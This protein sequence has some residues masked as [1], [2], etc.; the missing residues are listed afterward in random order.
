MVAK[1]RREIKYGNDSL[2]EIIAPSSNRTIKVTYWD[3]WIAIILSDMFDNNLGKMIDYLR[4]KANKT[5]HLRNNFEAIVNHIRLLNQ[6]YLEEKL[7]ITDI[8][9]ELDADFKKKQR[10]KAKRKILEMGFQSQEKSNWMINTPRKLHEV[11]AMRGH[12][13]LFP[14]SPKNHAI[15][16]EN[17]YK[18]PGFYNEEQSFKLEKKLDKYL[19]KNK[20]K[21][22][23]SEL[24]ALYRAF[25]TVVIEKMDMVDDSYGVIGDL[26]EDAL[27]T[28]F[29]LDRNK[30][31]MEP[32]D[33]FLDFI[34][35][36]IWED[37]G[38]TD[39]YKPELLNNLTSTEIPLVESILQQQ[40][41]ELNNLELHYQ[42][43][44]AVTM[45]RML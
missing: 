35:L 38:F 28:Y 24:F 2:L 32:I 12:W 9:V 39:N 29:L 10:I 3:L 42:A 6:S 15:S 26:Y 27:K 33:F 8:L 34:E 37:Y 31:D 36:L 17:L 25:L 19:D 14:V 16:L 45:L 4:S 20:T 21:A 41:D 44:K 22:S 40:R 11:Q 13:H 30:L 23:H 18:S 43:K 5:S 7:Y 1:T